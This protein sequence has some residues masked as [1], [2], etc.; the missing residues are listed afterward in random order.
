MKAEVLSI[1]PQMASNYLLSNKSNRNINKGRVSLYAKIISDGDWLLNG[2]SIKFDTNGNLID[3]QH[4]LAAIIQSK[5]QIES[6]VITGAPVESFKTIDTG[7]SRS[8]GDVMKIDNIINSTSIAA[9]VIRYLKLSVG[10]NH[11]DESKVAVGI[12]N[13]NVLD[14]Y[15]LN[16]DLYQRLFVKGSKFYRDNFRVISK[17]DYIGF[18]RFFQS[19]Y[20]EE[21]IELFFDN[22]EKG[23]GVCGLLKT[24]LLQNLVSK[25]KITGLEKTALIIKAFKYFIENKE[26]KLL[27]FS[28]EESFPTILYKPHETKTKNTRTGGFKTA[29]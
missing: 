10:R 20:S 6:I 15:N 14:E 17:S 29:N 7:R 28:V 2:E 23:L 8:A 16:E 19:K 27:R 11:T 13:K 25:K 18:Y 9:G 4:R 26:V 12:S 24:K 22:V 5:K 1:T 21:S 3:G